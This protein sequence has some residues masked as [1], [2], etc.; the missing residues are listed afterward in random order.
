MNTNLL[1]LHHITAITSSSPKI[2]KFMTE[3]L[4]LH[5][6][7]KTVNQDDVRTY[8]L[9]FTDDMGKAGTDLTFFDFPGIPRVNKEKTVLLGLDSVFQMTRPL[10]GGKTAL[11]NLMFVTK[12]LKRVLEPSTFISMILTISNI[13]LYQMKLIM[14]FRLA[15]HIVTVPYLQNM[16]SAA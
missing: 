1:G 10:T 4:G 13:N 3:I 5:L 9:Y 8:H 2:F 7:K 11:T 6:I 12:K 14:G 15:I 16:P